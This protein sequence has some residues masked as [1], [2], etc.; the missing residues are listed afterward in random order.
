MQ[1]H[2]PMYRQEFLHGTWI[3]P[4]EAAYPNGGQTR[5]GYAIFPDGKRRRIWAGIPDTFFSIPAHAR[6]DGKYLSG[7][8]GIDDH[9]T[10]SEDGKDRINSPTYGALM[11]YSAQWNARVK[12]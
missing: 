6:V 12:V 11:F 7:W 5:K 3:Y 1:Y 8:V 4:E 9:F 10:V 2:Y